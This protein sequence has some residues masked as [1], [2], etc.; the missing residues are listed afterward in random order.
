[1]TI[2]SILTADG[3]LLCANCQTVGERLVD[4]GDRLQEGFHQEEEP[5]EDL[6]GYQM[7]V[8][9]V[10]VCFKP[11]KRHWGFSESCFSIN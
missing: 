8:K 9:E 1:M 5:K 6:I 2:K 10:W 7:S 3:I 4:E 11:I